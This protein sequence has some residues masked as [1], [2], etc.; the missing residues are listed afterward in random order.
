MKPKIL[1]IYIDK[2]AKL[3]IYPYLSSFFH[4]YIDID[5]QLFDQIDLQKLPEYQMLLFSSALCR[6]LVS[7][8][9]SHLPIPMHQCSRELNYTY[10]HKILEIPPGSD[11]CIINVG[12]KNCEAIKSSLISLGFS[13][14][15]YCIYF[16]GGPAISPEVQ[17]AIT[18]G[19]ARLAPSTIKYIIDI[20]NRNVDIATLCHII[21]T[22][23]LPETILNQVT[24][25]F[26]GYIGNFMRYIRTEIG[27]LAARSYDNSKLLDYLDS[28]IC[29]SEPDGTILHVNPAF[30]RLLC[31]EKTALVGRRL[32]ELF[33]DW[34]YLL[35]MDQITDGIP[36]LIQNANDEWVD[37]YFSRSY[38]DSAEK[39]RYLFFASIRKAAPSGMPALVQKSPPTK[40]SDHDAAILRM[41][42]KSPC[43]SGVVDQLLLLAEA[44]VP[45]LLLGEA[46]LLQLPLARF[47]YAA[48]RRSGETFTYINAAEEGESLDSCFAGTG[49]VIFIDHLEAAPMQFQHRLCSLLKLQTGENR[50]LPH[51]IC[52]GSENLDSHAASGQFLPELFYHFSAFALKL[53]KLRDM[54]NEIPDFFRFYF[55]CMFPG[56][57]CHPEDLFSAELLRFLYSYNYPG[58]FQE[59][60]NLIRYFSC[61]YKG[62]KLSLDS[63]PPYVRYVSDENAAALSES[64]QEILFLVKA[65]PHCGRNRIS[66]LL[67]ESGHAL[68][69]HQIRSILTKL[70]DDGYIEILKTKQGCRI[71][72]L[73]EYILS[74]AGFA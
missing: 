22:F 68:T 5:C 32:P 49:G 62:K 71:T 7:E 23:G 13:Q 35:R 15:Q 38:T 28:G 53:P 9:V 57:V 39:T 31:L 24:A 4:S 43:F 50:N 11:V 60:E 56:T 21:T 51:I 63:L 67:S 55:G 64:E 65:Y 27:K 10:L 8:Q 1:L 70:S 33:K 29:I 20:G 14:Y 54:K 58:N 17:Y 69:A 19:E 34:H 36:L 45:I 74:K 25:S 72:E 66:V 52:S 37:F 59:M 16:P 41:F 47:V 2:N 12:L 44:E 3:G 40:M 46:G 6:N 30:C 73:G 18:P 42:K 26:A 61:I 48:S